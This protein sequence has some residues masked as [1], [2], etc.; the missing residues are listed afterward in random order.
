MRVVTAI[1][2]VTLLVSSAVGQPAESEKLHNVALTTLGATAKGSGAPFNKDW[3]AIS[4][5]RPPGQRGGTIFG[6]AMAGGRVDVRLV[7]PVDIKAIELVCLNYNG[8]IQI[9]GVDIY[10]EG[11]LVKHADLPETPGKPH[12]IVLAAR[13]Q[14]IGIVATGKHPIRTL[15]NGRKGPDWGG[16]DRI[17][18]LSTTDVAAMMKDVE[19]YQVA[20][21]A[22]NIAPTGGS[23][24]VGETRVYGQPRQTKGHPCTI[25]D[26]QDI[27]HYKSMLKTSEELQKQFQG[28]VNSMDQRMKMPLGVPQPKKGPDGKWMHLPSQEYGGTHTQLAL[29]IANLG[30]VY[31]LSGE[32]R[33]AEFA[34]KLLLAYAEVYDKYAPGNRPGF[35]HDVG[36]C[37]DQRLGDATWLIQMA[38]G[39]DLIYNLPSITETE[40]KHIEDDLLK[41]SAK[42]IAANRANLISPTNWSAIGTCAILITGYAT[43]D[44]ELIDLAMYGR[45]GT[46]ELAASTPTACGPKG[47]W[48]T[49]S[50]PWRP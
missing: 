42:F 5:L 29:D 32:A 34:K 17:G 37:F 41:A 3:P 33:Y 18:V 19:E 44:R 4:A 2:V 28:L 50:W 31:V 11:K 7:V 45:G 22:N 20:A 26:S 9:S 15:A 30:A 43:D 47:R 46:K 16:W 36:K 6:G 8:T 23:A 13:G 21:A 35:T 48:A 12:R 40:R 24:A 14:H 10:V 27:D 38:R 1:T 49:S 39:Y 25:W